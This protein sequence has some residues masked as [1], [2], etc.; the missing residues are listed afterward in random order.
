MSNSTTTLS[1][2]RCAKIVNALLKDMGVEKVLPP[3]M[4][5]TYVK[6]GYITSQ[7]DGTVTLEDLQTWFEKY[8]AK[9]TVPVQE[10]LF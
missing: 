2:Y 6:K 3:Q 5:Y 10:R 4:F 8:S 1:P 7:P 9:L